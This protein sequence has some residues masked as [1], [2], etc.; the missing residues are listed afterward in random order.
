MTTGR[1]RLNVEHRFSE[2]GDEHVVIM[3]DGRVVCVVHPGGDV[4]AWG[5]VY[6]DAETTLVVLDEKTVVLDEKTRAA[7]SVGPAEEP[8]QQIG[9]ASAEEGR[10]RSALTVP[11][12]QGNIV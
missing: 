4:Q 5:T 11:E 1:T 12:P 10:S 9:V 3:E 7:Y 8:G 6:T 2:N